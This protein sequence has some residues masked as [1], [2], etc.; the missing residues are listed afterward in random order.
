MLLQIIQTI[1][2]GYSEG[3]YNNSKYSI[4]KQT[5]NNGKSYKIFAKALNGKD[6][7]SMNYYVT[8][9]NEFLKPCEMPEEKVIHFLE[10]VTLLL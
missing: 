2:E 5:F 4:T 1:E 3:L 9:Q 10:N 8:S 7:I 6:F